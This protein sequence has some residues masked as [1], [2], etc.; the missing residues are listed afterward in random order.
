[1]NGFKSRNEVERIREQY[2]VGTRI[3]LISMDDP[4]TPV[5]SGMMGT[6]VI[7][8]G[9]GT[10]HMKWDNGRTLGIVPGEDQFRVI[11][12]PAEET[13]ESDQNQGMG[14]LNL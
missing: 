4:Y 7:V 3:E 14:G 10:L 13:M 5:E 6:V 9:A 8:D 1:M 12:K 2:P 11:S